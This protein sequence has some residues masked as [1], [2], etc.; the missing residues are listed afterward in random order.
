MA[1]NQRLPYHP[2]KADALLL[3][4]FVVVIDIVAVVVVVVVV[5]S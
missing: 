1:A 3:E 5:I 2:P 4:R